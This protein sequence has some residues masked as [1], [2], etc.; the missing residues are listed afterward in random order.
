MEVLLI[1]LA[2][3][4]VVFFG[5]FVSGRRFGPLALSLA[6]GFMLARIWA[7]WLTIMVSG[8]GFEIP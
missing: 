7:E 3:I 4:I 5:V 6:A 8:L 2:I 1:F